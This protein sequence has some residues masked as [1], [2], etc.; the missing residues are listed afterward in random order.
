MLCK[1]SPLG[2]NDIHC[3]NFQLFSVD[4]EDG[5]PTMQRKASTGEDDS[6]NVG[7]EATDTGSNLLSVP[8]SG[9]QNSLTSNNVPLDN[10]EEFENLK[11]KKEKKAKGV[12]L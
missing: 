1:K 6:G 9:S 12:E 7:S 3:L 8:S 11:Q 4:F 2:S 10:A 5:T